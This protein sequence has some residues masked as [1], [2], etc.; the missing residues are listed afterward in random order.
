[1][2][3]LDAT[4]RI[5]DS[6]VILALLALTLGLAVSQNAAAHS[7]DDSIYS[8]DRVVENADTSARAGSPTTAEPPRFTSL[9]PP[10]PAA[11]GGNRV[12]WSGGGVAKNAGANYAKTK[13]SKTLEMTLTGRTLEKL[14]YNRVTAKLWDA[15]SW[16]FAR[17]AK[18]D[19]HVFL[20]PGAPR[21]GSTFSRIEKPILERNGNPIIEHSAGSP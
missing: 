17:G 2:S 8:Y 13:G 10:T 9:Q 21:S 20:G 5:G 16:R 4:R 12:F 15:V 19:A 11:R 7:Y 14:P 3:S 18:G 1:M 6:A